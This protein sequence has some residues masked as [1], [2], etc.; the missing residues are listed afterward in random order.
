M[1]G[2]ISDKTIGKQA[3]IGLIEGNTYSSGGL[4]PM[5]NPAAV[6]QQ[7][8]QKPF[9]TNA[10]DGGTAATA[11]GEYVI[12]GWNPGVADFA[13]VAAVQ[14]VFPAAVALSSS[15]YATITVNKRAL[16]TPGTAQ[17]VATFSTATTSATA[18]L[19]VAATLAS[20]NALLLQPGDVLTLAVTKTG[21]GV[22]LN[23]FNVSVYL[24][25]V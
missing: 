4:S 19:A 14:V 1:S 24:E 12:A 7:L 8:A 5:S 10:T 9:L 18:W 3:L 17:P 15:N 16:L 21:T 11:V 23:N 13:R 2:L 22:A 25:E 20:T 6:V